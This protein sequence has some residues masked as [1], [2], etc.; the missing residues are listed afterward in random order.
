LLYVNLQHQIL[1]VLLALFIYHKHGKAS[2]SVEA[3]DVL[4][5]SFMSATAFLM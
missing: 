5:C 4:E 2:A 1:V 3:C